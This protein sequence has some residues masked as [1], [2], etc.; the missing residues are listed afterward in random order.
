MILGKSLP[1]CVGGT[2]GGHTGE[3]GHGDI[4]LTLVPVVS[5][6]WTCTGTNTDHWVLVGSVPP[7][8]PHLISVSLSVTA[9]PLPAPNWAWKWE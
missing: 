2:K 4:V 8:Q 7:A 3:F 6:T 1:G 9:R 5:H